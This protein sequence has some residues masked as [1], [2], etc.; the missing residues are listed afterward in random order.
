MKNMRKLGELQF[1]S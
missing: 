1:R